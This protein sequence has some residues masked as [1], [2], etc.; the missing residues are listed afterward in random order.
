MG[1]EG[2]TSRD[3]SCSIPNLR[4]ISIYWEKEKRRRKIGGTQPST[5]END[6]RPSW[7]GTAN[8]GHGSIDCEDGVLSPNRGERGDGENSERSGG[9]KI[10]QVPVENSRQRIYGP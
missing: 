7:M 2:I 4:I 10:N 8:I 1:V 3:E 6:G 5:R 9:E